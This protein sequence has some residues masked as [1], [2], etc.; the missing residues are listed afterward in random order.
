[1]E[2][3]SHQQWSWPMA[4]GA[5]FALY[6][7]CSLYS[8][9][10][11]ILGNIR[12]WPQ[13][14]PPATDAIPPTHP[15]KLTLPA[16]RLQQ[17]SSF[18][19]RSWCFSSPTFCSGERMASSTPPSRDVLSQD[20]STCLLGVYRCLVGYPKTPCSPVF[21]RSVLVFSST[22]GPAVRQ[23]AAPVSGSSSSFHSQKNRQPLQ[24]AGAH[25]QV[26]GACPRAAGG[27]P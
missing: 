26:A 27:C 12:F 13:Q 1:M 19:L 21:T 8:R 18:L 6:G 22:A 15:S 7:V 11:N 17:V 9:I 4:V 16:F 23:Q 24:A 3:S 25:P 10:A 20:P 5:V 14:T 2:D